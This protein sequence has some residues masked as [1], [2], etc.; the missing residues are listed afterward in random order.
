MRIDN[1]GKVGIGSTSPAYP[2]D[3]V[4]DIRT[5]GCLRYASSTLGTCASDVQ[6]KRDVKPFELGLAAVAGLK[7]VTFY[8]NGLAGNPDDGHKQIGL[9]AQDVE[10]VA[11][12]LVVSEKVKLHPKDKD[13]TE[14]KAVDY[15]AVNYMLINA[16]KELK[17]DNDTLRAANDNEAAQIKA[18]TAR[19]D[20]LD[21]ARR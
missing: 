6:I 20:A 4:G 9:I 7:P 12:A 1:N 14:I 19:L 18:L 8:Y 5:S 17:A 11:P 16:V 15:G 21:G 3:V 13:A 2:L 10:K